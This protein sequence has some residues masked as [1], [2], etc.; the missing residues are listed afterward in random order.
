MAPAVKMGC[1]PSQGSFLVN[2]METS[3]LIRNGQ[4]Q[5]GEVIKIGTMSHDPAQMLID[6]EDV[7]V[8][9]NM[10]NEHEMTGMTK[11]I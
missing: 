6:Q 1:H 2:D 9:D 11:K 5:S 8:T 10:I 4:S 7:Y 3:Q